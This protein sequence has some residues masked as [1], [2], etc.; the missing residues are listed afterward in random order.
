MQGGINYVNPSRLVTPYRGLNM[1]E[2]AAAT[3]SQM[4]SFLTT[5]EDNRTSNPFTYL[6]FWKKNGKDK[7][8]YGYVTNHPTLPDGHVVFIPTRD[9]MELFEGDIIDLC[10][11][12]LTIKLGPSERAKSYTDANELYKR[13]NLL[14]VSCSHTVP[15]EFYSG[16]D[17]NK[18]VGRNDSTID[19]VATNPEHT[20]ES[21]TSAYENAKYL[22]AL[23]AANCCKRPYPNAV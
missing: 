18:P 22:N 1:N 5:K 14:K 13:R 21:S 7:G 4:Y 19:R 9:Y 20:H 10:G 3:D 6:D 15:D 17:S 12:N 8:F 23:Y 11:G 16:K 2:L